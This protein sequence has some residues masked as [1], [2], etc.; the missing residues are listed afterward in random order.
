MRS[1][2]KNHFICE[3]T[4][5]NGGIVY[6]SYF[7]GTQAQAIEHFRKCPRLRKHRES[8]HGKHC[9]ITANPI[10]VFQD[11]KHARN[12]GEFFELPADR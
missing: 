11:Y 6:S 12:D 2:A 10:L 8:W 5:I 1:K 3:V 4:D 9:H 7:D